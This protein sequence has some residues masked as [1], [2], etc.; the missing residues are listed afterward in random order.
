MH[1]HSAVIIRCATGCGSVVCLP[2]E[3]HCRAPSARDGHINSVV[4]GIVVLTFQFITYRDDG[5]RREEKQP[6][7]TEKSSCQQG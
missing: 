6:M 1:L 3:S 4:T 2:I 7:R 5:G